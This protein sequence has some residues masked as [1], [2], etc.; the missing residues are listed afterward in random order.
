MCDPDSQREQQQ[1]SGWPLV[2]SFNS[3]IPIHEPF[4]E[5]QEGE[6]GE[7][8]KES[9]EF[10]DCASVV[11]HEAHTVRGAEVDARLLPPFADCQACD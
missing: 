5:S 10:N 3:L 8:V 9:L 6:S 7:K 4:D 11:A 1:L 2:A